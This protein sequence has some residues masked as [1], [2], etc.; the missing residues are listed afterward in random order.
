[1]IQRRQPI[2]RKVPLKRSSVRIERRTPVRK[3]KPSRKKLD[4]IYGQRRKWFLSQ[5]EN[6]ICPMALA[7]VLPD[8]NGELRPHHRAATTIHHA[9]R[10]GPYY[11]EESTWM[12]TS[13]EGNSWV[14]RNKEEARKRG[15]LCD[16]A[17][18]RALWRETHNGMPLF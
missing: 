11:L 10:R 12:G 14:E 13:W 15:W 2:R 16:T 1:M 7:G 6:S 5:Q 18:A 3:V 8:I 17:E 9:W 4:L